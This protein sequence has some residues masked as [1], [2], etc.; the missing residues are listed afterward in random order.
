[1][2]N[3]RHIPA[4]HRAEPVQYSLYRARIHTSVRRIVVSTVPLHIRM[5]PLLLKRSR[6]MTTAMLHS[7]AFLLY[8]R[9]VRLHADSR[10]A[11]DSSLA[12][13]PTPATKPNLAGFIPASRPARNCPQSVNGFTPCTSTAPYTPR[14]VRATHSR[15]APSTP[16]PRS[17]R[18]PRSSCCRQSSPHRRPAR[19][20]PG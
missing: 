4:V 12:G 20:P 10:R 16:G 5:H 15:L 17:P 13:R 7:V 8:S 9:D 11:C 19:P 3:V 18:G 6:F 14:E 1:M 2:V